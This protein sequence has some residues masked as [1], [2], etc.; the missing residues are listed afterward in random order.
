MHRLQLINK[1]PGAV[2]YKL[3]HLS[4]Q[5]SYHQ[6]RSIKGLANPGK[7]AVA[8]YKEFQE[9]WD[10]MLYQ[11]E[12]LLAK[13]KNKTIEQEYSEWK[14]ADLEILSGKE[15]L[16]IKRL[17]KTRVN[18]S[19]FRRIILNNYSNTCAVC[20]LNIEQLVV[21]SHILKWSEN[22]KERLNP[23]NGLCL[24][25]IHDK[26]FELGYIG[27]TA[28]Y[29]LHISEALSSVSEETYFAMFKRHHQQMMIMPD[30]FYPNPSFLD[31]HYQAAFR[32]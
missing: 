19:L 22:Q 10:E 25:S 11:S 3:V 18:Q 30:K 1:T 31:A 2:A 28:G 23:E 15:G 8:V 26:S 20:G 29:R 27:I 17:V 7:N 14:D 6:N 16:D 4:S 9:N 32:K 24:C 5:D 21:A 12:V 13:Y